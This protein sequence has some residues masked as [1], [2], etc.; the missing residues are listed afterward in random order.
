MDFL[1]FVGVKLGLEFIDDLRA[2]LSVVPLQCGPW[3]KQMVID[4]LGSVRKFDLTTS[5][6]DAAAICVSRGVSIDVPVP[7]TSQYE[8][9]LQ[10]ALKK[11]TPDLDRSQVY[12]GCLA[13]P[14]ISCEYC[15]AHLQKNNPPTSVTLYT[16]TGPIPM[17]KV[18]LRCRSCNINYCMSKYG[19]KEEGYRYYSKLRAVAEASDACYIDR[20]VMNVFCALRYVYELLHTLF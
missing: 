12:G 19:S 1:F 18:E 17:K 13:P 9:I 10:K 11:T 20:L 4:L 8:L 2:V 7:L 16:S 5:E 6:Q 14:T 3:R 15:G